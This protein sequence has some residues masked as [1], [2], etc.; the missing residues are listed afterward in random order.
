VGSLKDLSGK[1]FGRLTVICRHGSVPKNPR[2]ERIT[3]LCKCTCGNEKIALGEKLVCGKTSSC[4]C[5]VTPHEH[6]AKENMKK[7][8]KIFSYINIKTNCWEW[9]KFK[10]KL[11]YGQISYRGKQMKA[12]R[13]SWTVFKGD[14]PTGICVLHTCDNPKCVNPDH[15]FLGSMKDNVQDMMKKGRDGHGIAVGMLGANAKLTDDDVRKIRTFDNSWKTCEELSKKYDVNPMTIYR[16]Q[17][18]QTWK[19]LHDVNDIDS[20]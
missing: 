2:G 7:K 10:T 9:Q 4:G 15:L 16:I 13:A 5:I 18:R 14:I 6:E 8:I 12:H 11:G 17:K 19:H 3:W 20:N 1:T